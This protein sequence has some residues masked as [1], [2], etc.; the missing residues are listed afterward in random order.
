MR[1][2]VTIS[3]IW[4]DHRKPLTVSI[5]KS[6]L[7]KLGLSLLG[8]T[9]LWLCLQIWGVISYLERERLLSERHRLEEK[10]KKLRTEE[11]RLKHERAKLENELKKI[12]SL[13][14]KLSRIEEYMTARGVR[15]SYRGNVGGSSFYKPSEEESV[16]FLSER[17]DEVYKSIRSLPMGY[18]LYGRIVSAYGWRK[19]PFGRGYEFHTGLDIDAPE[20]SPVKAT[21]DGKVSFAGR[22]PDYGNTVII[23]H[24]SGYSTLYAHLSKVKVKS[25]QQVRAGDVVGYVGSTGRST[26]PHLHYE[27]IVGDRAVNPEKFLTWR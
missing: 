17:A 12:K 24:S 19:S 16:D 8:F 11:N 13:E 26:G 20:G 18:P 21:A 25:G 9:F 5:R 23:D 22:F 7:R 14:T 27:V 10:M 15:I 6:F 1:D 3:L 4:H 2:K